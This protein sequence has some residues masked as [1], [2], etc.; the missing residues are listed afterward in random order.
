MTPV[1]M[2]GESYA[3][4]TL[5]GYSLQ[6]HKELDMIEVAQSALMPHCVDM[7]LTLEQQGFELKEFTYMKSFSPDLQLTLRI[8]CCTSTG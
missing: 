6:R 1:F 3:Q 5:V 2:P 4:R 8:S 7:K